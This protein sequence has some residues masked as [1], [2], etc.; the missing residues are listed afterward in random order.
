MH[1]PDSSP[2]A[3]A[4]HRKIKNDNF[5]AGSVLLKEAFRADG[6]NNAT[7]ERTWAS[8]TK[9][10]RDDQRRKRTLFQQSTVE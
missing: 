8:E 10:L 4:N 2:C 3:A 6:A 9:V 5:A 1:G 7:R